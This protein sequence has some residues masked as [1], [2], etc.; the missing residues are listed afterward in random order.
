MTSKK[1]PGE[2]KRTRRE[3]LK[4]AGAGTAAAAF[5]TVTLSAKEVQ[6]ATFDAEYDVVVCGGGGG[7]LPS[8]LFSRWLGNKVLVLEKAGTLGGTSFKAA[9]WYWVPNNAAMRKAGMEDSK[10][11]FL[12]YVARLSAPQTFDPNAPRYGLNEWEYSMCEAIWE[13]ASDG[14]ELLASKDALPYRHVAPVPDYFAEMGY[15]GNTGRV[16]F[17]KD[18]APTMSDG[19]RVATRTLS[20]ACRRDG[21]DI[22]TGH[23]VQKVI[24]NDKGEV[25]GV[26]AKAE[27][28]GV[29]RARAR[30]AV[31]FA[32][33]GFT[34]DPELRKNFLN[35][36]V[37]GGCAA[38]T[39]EGDFVRI[40]STL[41]VQL[42][43]M[44][45]AWTC[46]VSLE[47]AIA[48]DPSISGMFSVA[49][50]SM[51]FVDKRG[52]R[53]V[54]EK[55]Q[56]NELAQ[57]FFEWDGAKAQYP[58]LVLISIWDQ[59]AQD[60]SAGHEYGRLIVPP[61]TDD[62][63]VIKG[64]TLA[65]LAANIDARLQKYASH[66]G[67]MR[68]TPDF[69]ANVT[70]SI[71]R[72]NELAAT[73]KDLDFGRGD[74]PVEHLFNGNVKE[75]PGRTNPTMWP[76]SGQ[77][78]YYA[79][80]VTGGTLDTKGGP[81]TNNNGQVL[82]GNN[83]PIPGLYGVGNCV[84]SASGRAYWAGGATLGPIIAFAYRAANTANREPVKS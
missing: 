1:S 17:P 41:G 40:A 60:N 8:A 77:G 58:Y 70:A 38:M 73:G 12:K 35:I 43:N 63:H 33:G 27:G 36:P 53:V 49:G 57:K 44:N 2:N 54:N 67:G 31:I 78:P 62:R 7:G 28:G 32:T 71:A 55:L 74:R 46:P 30:K 80:L 3:F 6:A 56:Y 76:I 5:G 82:D 64:N 4:A 65:E 26:E 50:D 19:G 16:L 51:I 61:G 69:T 23:R 21:V 66:I 22:K 72:F 45:Y 84:A 42:R 24:L 18:G 13:S 29:Y 20:L 37:Y 39:N 15:K 48:R 14:A 52:K 9:Y 11:D 79:A 25:L 34:H 83:E 75:E 59:R 10:S 81:K 68:V 47:K